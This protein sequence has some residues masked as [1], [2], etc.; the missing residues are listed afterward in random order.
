MLFYNKICGNEDAKSNF[1]L[2]TIYMRSDTKR[3]RRK[4]KQEMDK[5]YLFNKIQS[6]FTL[7]LCFTSLIVIL[8]SIF[9]YLYIQ[10]PLKKIDKEKFD[11]ERP[12]YY[13]LNRNNDSTDHLENIFTVLNSIGFKRTYDEV[14]WNLLWSHQYPFVTF[15]PILQNL[16]P[17]QLINH[18]PGCGYITNKKHLSTSGAYYLPQSY[19]IPQDKNRLLTHA[20]LNP[21]KLWLK[22]SNNHRGIKIVKASDIIYN[23]SESFI[24]D[25][26]DNPFLIDGYKFDLGVYV[27]FT[28]IDPLRVYI[29]KGDVLLRFCTIK[30][31]PFDNSQEDSYII[32]DDYRPIWEVP[33]LN[34]YYIRLGYSMKDS[35]YAYMRSI[36]KDFDNIWN[37][38][39]QAIEEIAI[40]KEGLI[41]ESI[42]RHGNKRNYFELVRFDFIIDED[43]KVHVMEANMSPNLSSAHYPP[44]QLLYQQV[45]FNLFSLIGINS[46]IK[47]TSM[48]KSFDIKN[49]LLHEIEV[50]NKNLAV[51]PQICTTCQDCFKVECQLCISCMTEEI[52]QIL[53][54]SYKEHQNKLD[55]QRIFPPSP[56]S[57]IVLHKYSLKNQL[58]IKWYQGKC[59]K[60]PLWCMS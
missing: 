55:F 59:E 49:Q 27:A 19:R 33:S 36:G 46:R 5:I 8:L 53:I 30:Y 6:T 47:T 12:T 39:I 56:L 26:I 57:H 22:K 34:N 18:F 45:L 14:N 4:R 24:Q 37:Q 9:Y 29:Y 44:N 21:N 35:L 42:Q 28:S 38:I 60:D 40:M 7:F 58:L 43:M 52:K 48:E 2:D 15:A 51:L 16:K 31:E 17:H 20:I 10:S 3:M 54:Q 1:N 50:A 11:D 32:G 25:F 13:V 41:K 23:D